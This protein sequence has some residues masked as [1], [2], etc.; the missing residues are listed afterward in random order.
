MANA[1]L[2]NCSG[3]V[4]VLI[5]RTDIQSLLRLGHFSKARSLLSGRNDPGSLIERAR[6]AFFLDNDLS[7]TERLA[8]LARAADDATAGQRLLA[9]MFQYCVS[10][11]RGE[12]LGSVLDAQELAGIGPALVSEV[13]YYA[14]YA[15]YFARDFQTAEVW[16]KSHVPESVDWRAR[17][18]VVQGLVAAARDNFADQAHYTSRALT[19]LESGAPDHV[20]LISNAARLLSILVR[21]VPQLGGATQLEHALS[22]LGDDDGFTGA[23]FHVVRSLAWASALRGD[24]HQAMG[25]IL[26]AISGATGDFE[27]LYAYLDFA[28]VSVFAHEQGS[29]SARAA[30]SIA[31]QIA[32]KISWGEV[33]T[34]DVAALPL[35]AQVA[36]EFG[37]MN[38]ARVYCELAASRQGRI[39]PRL[40]LAHD[41]RFGAMIQESTALAYASLN[42]KRAIEAATQAFE[43]YSRIGFAW[44]AA[45]MAIFLL[46]MTHSN[47]WKLRAKAHLE[48]YPNGP[49]HR[50]LDRPSR[51]TRRQEDVLGLL[52]LGHDDDRIASELGISYKT[53][54]IHVGRIF[55]WYGVKSRSALMAR[56]IASGQ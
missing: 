3:A 46:Q 54:R 18:L 52:R 4:N 50:L 10:A 48:P 31:K 20:Y 28:S 53:V 47:Q 14:A 45:R 37:S 29:S 26:G 42:R 33:V 23:R 2:V 1:A 17:F 15:A 44:R 21:D 32:D 35:A 25:L 49:F 22:R 24:Y 6:L 7:E 56:A 55:H 40:A 13:I 8:T 38:D 34:D 27:R 41:S 9:K 5:E 11:C 16:L 39:V 43:T 12:T 30:F 36:A 19:L 51:L